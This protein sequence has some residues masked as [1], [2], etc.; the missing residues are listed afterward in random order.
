M[1]DGNCD[2]ENARALLNFLIGTNYFEL[3]RVKKTDALKYTYKLSVEEL[4][5]RCNLKYISPEGYELAKRDLSTPLQYENY[6]FNR[7]NENVLFEGVEKEDVRTL[8]RNWLKCNL[9][10]IEPSNGYNGYDSML[11]QIFDILEKTEVVS[12]DIYRCSNVKSYSIFKEMYYENSEAVSKD[13]SQ[14]NNGRAA[15]PFYVDFINQVLCYGYDEVKRGVEENLYPNDLTKLYHEEYNNDD[16]F[17]TRHIDDFMI[18][19]DGQNFI[20]YG[21]P[22]CG[23]SYYVA[24]TLLKGV[25]DDR[26]IRTTFYQ[27]YTNTDFVGQILPYVQKDEQGKEVVTYKFNP[28]PFTLALKEAVKN[29]D[30]KVYLVVEELNRGNAPAIFGD[31]FQLLDRNDNGISEYAITNINIR[32]YLNKELNS[33]F[34]KIK[35]PG[36]LYIYA[37]M[38]TSDQNVYTLDTAFKRRWQFVKLKNQFNDYI[39]AL[40]N[41][42]IHDY[43]SYK[44]P[45]L[46]GVTWEV[47]VNTINK[48]II[49]ATGERDT[50]INVS[51]KQIGVYFIDKNGLNMD[52][53]TVSS[54]TDK[55][56]AEKFAYKIFS[57]LWDDVAKFDKDQLFQK[58]IITL[59]DLILNYVESKQV[60]VSD[61]DTIFRPQDSNGESDVNEN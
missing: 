20:I 10:S 32:D 55:N 37:T 33:N 60:F 12:K 30:K 41:T 38:N 29:R 26:V 3:T 56:K 1:F 4:A 39:D 14:K 59:D 24:N 31:I 16:K 19:G 57:Y 51:D 44:V 40:G 53:E 42:H 9:N 11:F 43:R 54:L 5:K 6:L 2:D 23:K 18:K 45:G 8:F 7:K 36:N 58:N 21:T 25:P 35:I 47:F 34:D 49:G 15:F 48:A 17:E 61:I 46:N 50:T 27:D 52:T 28:G 22:G 13:N